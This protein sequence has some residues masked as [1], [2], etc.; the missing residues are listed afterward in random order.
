[1][2]R[3]DRPLDVFLGPDKAGSS[4][5]HTLLDGI[6]DVATPTPK[7]TFFFDRYFDRGTAWYE[8][9]FPD[10]GSRRIEVCHDYLFSP[11]AAARLATYAPEASG[12]MIARHPVERAFSAYQYMIRQGRIR[13][14]TPFE[15]AVRDV[16]ELVNHG[17][18]GRHVGPWLEA[19]DG[20][21]VV[22]DF[23]LLRSDEHR[24]AELA[25]AAFGV[26]A[27]TALRDG[28]L[29]G[30]VRQMS[31]PRASGLA[32]IAKR[33]ADLLR[34]GGADGL[35]GRLKRSTVLERVLFRPVDE[36][37]PIPDRVHDEIAAL[38]VD[39]TRRLDRLVGTG[40]AAQ[41]WGA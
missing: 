28:A 25:L 23:E 41:W 40:F 30:R 16:E 8:A 3:D 9:R 2:R 10:T 31:Q 7:D 4:W 19:L 11:M 21:V 17:A 20:R 18:Y 14:G 15:A 34:E 1:M 33:T 6:P 27:S 26:P 5:L 32:R 37:K 12:L 29:P 24:F 36:P 13:P 22:L 35:L 38:L 39:D